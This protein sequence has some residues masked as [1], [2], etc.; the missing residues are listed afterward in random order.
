LLRLREASDDK[1]LVGNGQDCPL[2]DHSGCGNLLRGAPVIATFFPS[3]LTPLDEARGY[4]MCM[5]MSAVSD[6]SA[7]SWQQALR[8][9]PQ[10]PL[11]SDMELDAVILQYLEVLQRDWN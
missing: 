4:A 9:V 3:E 8:A 1:M 11:E 10:E 6:A 5:I 7:Y 2:G